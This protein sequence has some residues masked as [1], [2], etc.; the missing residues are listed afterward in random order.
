M[1]LTQLFRLFIS[2]LLPL[3][4]NQCTPRFYAPNGLQA[5]LFREKGEFHASVGYNGGETIE[6][7]D[8]QAAYAIT[9]RLAV[10]TNGF[11]K[12]F[13]SSSTSDEFG[14]SFGEAAL[15]YFRPFGRGG[16]FEVYGGY[17]AGSARGVYANGSNSFYSGGSTYTGDRLSGRFARWFVQPN[18]GYTSRGFDIAFSLRV[19]GLRLHDVEAQLRAS[20]YPNEPHE[21]A[22]DVLMLQRA[23]SHLLVEPALTLRGGWKY[24][25]L[26]L[27]GILSGNLSHTQTEFPM[28]TSMIRLGLR[29]QVA[30]RYTKKTNPYEDFAQP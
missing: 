6:G 16:S 7:T 19:A 28:E 3:A 20:Q 5:P 10:M 27:Q 15:G 13:N 14:F 30:P 26:E 25:K 9:P 18:L 8:V 2:G 29:L 1:K 17:G 12:G 22:K 4:L 23:S 24:V 11:F 21:A